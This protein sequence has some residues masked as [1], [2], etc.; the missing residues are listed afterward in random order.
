MFPTLS[1]DEDPKLRYSLTIPLIALFIAFSAAAQTQ[2]QVMP[3]SSG[4]HH[5][6]LYQSDL[7]LVT[8][9]FDCATPSTDFTIEGLPSALLPASVQIANSSI[10]HQNWQTGLS[11]EQRLADYVGQELTLVHLDRAESRTG[12]LLGFN[13]AHLEFEYQ[14]AVLRYPIHGEWQPQLPAYAPSKTQ[15]S[16]KLPL[17]LGSSSFDLSYL[18]RG[19]SWQTEYQIELQGETSVDLRARAA[20]HNR[21][22]ADFNSATLKLLAGNPRMP[23]QFEP[24][25]EIRAMASAA[26]IAADTVSV[27]EVQGYQLFTLPNTY[28][29]SANSTQ[30]IPL[31]SAQG[32]PAKV[33]YQIRHPAY[34]GM[35]PG[36]E[37]QYAQ[38]QLRVD[39]D[40]SRIDKPLPAGEVE[41]FKRDSQNNLQFV[42]SQRLGQYSPGQQIELNYGEVFDLR[43]QRRQTEYQRNG[44]TYL[45]GYEVRL[46]NGADEARAL[47]YQ[48]DVNEQWSLVDSSQ[49]ATV[50]GMQARWRVEVPA[51]GELTL[52][53]TLRLIR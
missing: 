39:L 6:T 41:L 34:H 27:S 48:V 38:Q 12:R 14:G 22:D 1:K 19:L 43:S 47:E 44:N 7:V 35:R 15:L 23:Q 4:Q 24:M 29:L 33:N 42:G 40:E 37:Q 16:L 5:L 18:S 17:A 21:S 30:R 26:P 9:R 10:S 46:I 11:F 51:K 50:D 3:Q 53:Y 49:P 31:L 32:L 52:S 28:T 2:P 45:Q 36:V 13:G 20:L 8:S 25:M